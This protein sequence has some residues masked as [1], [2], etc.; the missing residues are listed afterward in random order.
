MF[1]LLWHEI[2]IEFPLQFFVHI[3][4]HPSGWEDFSRTARFPFLF[5]KSS[6]LENSLFERSA[7][8]LSTWSVI[9]KNRNS[10]SISSNHSSHTFPVVS[11]SSPGVNGCALRFLLSV[12]IV[13][14][15]VAV[16]GPC[17]FSS[18]FCIAEINS[19]RCAGL[20]GFSVCLLDCSARRYVLLFAL[21]SANRLSSSQSEQ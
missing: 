11:W 6:L 20:A 19:S 5:E 18:R 14:G 3:Q 2:I 17:W 21:F 16:A 8:F 7:S 10:R 4:I 1:I 12:I 15:A 13:T 9:R